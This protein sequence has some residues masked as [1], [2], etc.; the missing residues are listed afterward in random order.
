[1]TLGTGGWGRDVGKDYKWA[2][3]LFRVMY[4]LIMDIYVKIMKWYMLSMHNLLY[5]N[6]TS[7]NL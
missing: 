4:T 1:M 3:K 5:I 7:R 6:Y 2:Q